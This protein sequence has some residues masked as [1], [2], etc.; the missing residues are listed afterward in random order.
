MSETP[1]AREALAQVIE[2]YDR[3]AGAYRE[4]WAPILRSAAL[5]L[6]R[7][8]QGGRVQRVLDVGAGVGV[9][10]PDLAA[11]FPR[12]I[13]TAVDRSRGMLSHAP[14]SY[15]RA[16][17]NARQLAVSSNVVDRVFL[18]F[19]LFHLDDPVR[20]LREAHRVLRP[21]GRVATLTWAGDL[22]SRASRVWNECL[23]AHGAVAPDPAADARHEAVDAPSK[24]DA[25]L[26]EAGFES[27]RSW[28][29]DLVCAIDREKLVRLKTSLGSSKTR[30]DSLDPAT[31]SACV[32][33]ARHRMSELA[34]EDFVARGGVVYA[35]ASR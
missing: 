30:F 26:E 10:L 8:L 13:V 20:A 15:G 14:D 18:L 35:I 33:E 17:M 2:R 9:L 29:D 25:L 24:M 27:P 34:E 7:E 28:S 22:E 3:S 1:A 12:A 21:H 19:M 16:L 32:E 23:D 5:P 4:L 6:L 11:A 31:A